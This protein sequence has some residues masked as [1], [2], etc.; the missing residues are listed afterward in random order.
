LG[1]DHFFGVHRRQVTIQHGGGVDKNIVQGDGW[2]F[3]GKAARLPH[4]PLDCLGQFPEM[5]VAVVQLAEGVADTNYRPAQIQVI[6]T[7]RLEKG[8]VGKASHTTFGEKSLAAIHL[9]I[10]D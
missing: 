10:H 1:P 3:Q 8:A 5:A 9:T 4:P 7:H 6:I 2:K